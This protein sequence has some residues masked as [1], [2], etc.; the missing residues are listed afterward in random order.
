MVIP[1]R[2]TAKGEE[3]IWWIAVAAGAAVAALLLALW[4]IGER[5]HLFLPSTR[6]VYRKHGAFFLLTVR[7]FHFYI[8]GCWPRLYIGFLIKHLFGFLKRRGPRATRWLA[9]HYHGKVLTPENARSIV[10]VNRDIPL[11]DLE[12]V[13]PYRMARSFVLGGSPDIAVLECP[14]RHVRQNPCQPTQVCMI[15]GQPFVDLVLDHH[16]TTSRRISQEEALV[17]LEAEHR[18]GHVHSAWFKDACFERFFAIC[19]CCKCCCGGIDAMVNHG[20]PMMASSGYVAEVDRERCEGCGSCEDACPFGAIRVDEQ[21]SVD[22][23]AC[24]G[25]GVCEGQCPADA[26]SLMLDETKGI[27]LD[28]RTMV[29]Q[30][31]YWPSS[32]SSASSSPGFKGAVHR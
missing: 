28:V 25:C 18:R 26:I 24:M 5:G 27:P 23:A 32:D 2:H 31:T 30:T 21:A 10:T 8:Y 22:R 1:A 9:D 19:N 7:G 15:V 16:P 20:V 14:C 3:M 4:L 17:L 6:G 29:E 13:I 12:R 11:R